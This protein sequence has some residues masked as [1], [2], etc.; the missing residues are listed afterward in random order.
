LRL[1]VEFY[2]KLKLFKEIYENFEKSLTKYENE[3]IMNIFLKVNEQLYNEIKSSF[4]NLFKISNFCYKNRWNSYDCILC[5]MTFLSETQFNEHELSENHI[6]NAKKLANSNSIF[7]TT[8]DINNVK[9]LFKNIEMFEP[10]VYLTVYEHNSNSL[11]W[12]ETKARIIYIPLNKE[13][14]LDYNFLE[15]SLM[16][17]KNKI[18]K[19]GSFIAAS[20][21]TGVYND[22]DYLSYLMHKFQ[23]IVFFD[24]AGAAPY[25]KIDMNRKLDDNYRE[26]LGFKSQIKEEILCYKDGIFFSPHKLLGGPNTPG[27]LIIKQDVVR[28]LLVPSEPGGGVVLYVRKYREK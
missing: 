7:N 18:I 27:V 10:I 11:P 5:R 2:Q 20:N 14:E 28:N 24:Y 25:I 1:Y 17:N 23:G 6:N 9:E 8:I 16:I 22:V 15:K 19:I 26:K 4:A 12:R 21:I 13:E 3:E